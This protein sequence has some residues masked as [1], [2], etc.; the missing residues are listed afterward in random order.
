MHLTLK[1]TRA[2]TI[3]VETLFLS[4]TMLYLPGSQIFVLLLLEVLGSKSELKSF[5][6]LSSLVM[7]YSVYYGMKV[8]NLLIKNFGRRIWNIFLFIAVS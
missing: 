6:A 2:V 4:G 8:K 5:I 3:L 7:N 1:A